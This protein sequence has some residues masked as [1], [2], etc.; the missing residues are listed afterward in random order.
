MGNAFLEALEIF[1]F[2][3]GNHI[4]PLF[5]PQSI[6][7]DLLLDNVDATDNKLANHLAGSLYDM[8]PAD[9]KTVKPAGEW[10]TII[11]MILQTDIPFMGNAFLEALE[12]FEF[13]IGNHI[14]PRMEHDR[15]QGEGWQSDAY[16]EW[17]EGRSV[18]F[19]EQRVGLVCQL[20]VGCIH[21]IQNLYFGSCIIDRFARNFAYIMWS[22][23]W[24]DMVANSKFKDFQGF[25]EG[26][27]HEGYI[28]L[29]VSWLS[30]L[31]PQY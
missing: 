19:V 13:A 23:E 7:N 6:L 11:T 28:G 26:I 14:I 8:L 24:D 30:D 27:S 29:Q 2:A 4:I 9:P 15:D 1:E 10:N 3:I 31:V 21:I 25:Q 5:A 18:Y 17:K 22:K 20:V 16:P 12:I